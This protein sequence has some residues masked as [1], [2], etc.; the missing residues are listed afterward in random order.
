MRPVRLGLAAV[1]VAVMGIA[2]LG[3]GMGDAPKAE[4]AAPTGAALT[5]SK[6]RI[7]HGGAQVQEGRKEFESEGCASC[8]AIAADG[9]KGVLGPRLDTDH[10]PADE[11]LGSITMPRKDIV[12]GYEA[13]LMPTNYAKKMSKG[14]LDAVVAYI[15]AASGKAKGGSSG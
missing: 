2:I 14:E 13:N 4:D 3:I 5:A 1:V 8:H 9:K 11:I 12:E 6:A 7:A 15:Q 10:D